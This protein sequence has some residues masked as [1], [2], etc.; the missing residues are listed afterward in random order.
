MENKKKFILMSIVILLSII[1]ISF[2][3]PTLEWSNNLF[4]NAPLN[5]SQKNMIDLNTIINSSQ[6]EILS[7]Y[8]EINGISFEIIPQPAEKRLFLLKGNN[9]H[10]KEEID[11]ANKIVCYELRISH[12][13]GT[14]ILKLPSTLSFEK[15]VMYFTSF[16]ADNI[17][18]IIDS[19]TAKCQLYHYERNFGVAPYQS[20]QLGFPY[21]K[22]W[23]SKSHR[24]EI[25]DEYFGLGLI[26]LKNTY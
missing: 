17:K 22:E 11:E 6:N 10:S 26:K 16:F 4:S 1:A 18:L 14:D 12:K 24:I 20:I 15:S 25:I 2:V 8:K 9:S 13:S 21:D 23:K 3:W 7:S 5:Q 19:D